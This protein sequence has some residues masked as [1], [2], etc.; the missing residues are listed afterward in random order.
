MINQLMS[1]PPLKKCD[2]QKCTKIS[3]IRNLITEPG[4]FLFPQNLRNMLMEFF[5]IK[6][7]GI[8]RF[9]GSQRAPKSTSL[10]P[11]NSKRCLTGYWRLMNDI[12]N[13]TFSPCEKWNVI[14]NVTVHLWKCERSLT[15]DVIHRSMTSVWLYLWWNWKTFPSFYEQKHN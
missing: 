1:Q 9:F 12:L 8:F 10:W 2:R 13:S 15:T 5:R 7:L 14:V 6:I 4:L 11:H 3:F